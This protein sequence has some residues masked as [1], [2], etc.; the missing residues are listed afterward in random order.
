MGYKASCSS[1]AAGAQR[2]RDGGQDFKLRRARSTSRTFSC[3]RAAFFVFFVVGLVRAQDSV[4]VAPPTDAARRATVAS[5]GRRIAFDDLVDSI[6]R[7][8]GR[9]TDFA[10]GFKPIVETYI[11]EKGAQYRFQRGVIS[12]GDD[13]FLGRL[14]LTGNSPSLV[15]FADEETWNQGGEKF[16][17]QDPLPFNQVAFAQALFPDFGHFDRRNYSFEFVRWEDLGEV[18]CAVLDVR[19][20]GNSKKRGFVGRIWVEDQDYDI[21][22]FNGAFTSGDL[23]KRAFH[24]DSWRLNTLGNWWM[25]AYVYTEE[26]KPDDLSSHTPW[27]KAQTRVWGYDLRN[28]GAHRENAGRTETTSQGEN[29]GQT[30][31]PQDF[32]DPSSAAAEHLLEDRVVDRS[33]FA[34][35]MAPDGQVNQILETVVNNI[36]ITNDLDIPGVRCRVLLTTP[37]ESFVMGRTIVVS[38]GLLD[39]LPDEATLAAVLAHE[40]AHVVLGHDVSSGDSTVFSSALPDSDI[41]ASLDF[42][43]N[44]TQE[45]DANKKGMELFSKSPYKGQFVS[46]SLFLE[47]LE[48]SSGRFPVLLHGRFGNDFDSSHLIGVQAWAHSH[49]LPKADRLDQVSALPIGSR[50]VIDPWSDRIEMSKSK[51]VPLLSKAEKIPFQVT[52]F[53]PHLRRLDALEKPQSG[54]QE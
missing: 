14:N 24:F 38:R 17:V 39:V 3:R 48:V 47:A 10:R 22:R 15:P 42:H 8:E 26:S 31:A 21:V 28:A 18:H 19:P 49:K 13:Y 32:P 9:L 27:F 7:Q 43:F 29:P 30:E 54:G 50:V 4:P 20:H 36:L 53:Y 52:P 46:A 12:N 23:A 6:V 40:L 45:T 5:P 25:P 37:L 2:L 51:P 16:F 33:Q 34:G 11:Q 44:R 41:F 35:L 1:R